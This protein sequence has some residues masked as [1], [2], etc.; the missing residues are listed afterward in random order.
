MPMCDVLLRYVTFAKCCSRQVY[1]VAYSYLL[2]ILGNIKRSFFAKHSHVVTTSVE[3]ET[4]AERKFLL[5]T[6][7]RGC[8]QTVN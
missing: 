8:G 2:Y 4:F 3:D 7:F 1:R 6:N 5:T